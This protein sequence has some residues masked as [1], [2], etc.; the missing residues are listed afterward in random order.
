MKETPVQTIRKFNPGMLQS[1]LE[2]I[3]QFVARG[4]ELR[5]VLDV[6]RSNVD[7][8]S[9]QHV[10]IVAPRGRGKTMLLARVAAELRTETA[11]SEHLL[12]VRVIEESHEILDL[13][14]LWLETLFQLAREVATDNP[15]LARDLRATHASLSSRWQEQALDEH[16][17]AAVLDAADLLDKQLVLMVENLQALCESNADD[18]GWKLR[19]TLQSEPK[20]ILLASAT[21]RFEGLDDAEQAF[22]ELFRT[23]ELHALSTDECRRLWQAAS[24]DEATGRQIR[25]LEILTGGSPRLIM[26]VAEFARHRS[27][28]LLMEELAALIDEHS[29]YF[30]SHI[31]I[32]PKTERRVYL[33]VIDLWKPSKPSEIA[34]RARRDIRLVSATLGRLVDRGAVIV[35][36]S[37]RKRLYSAT[38]RLYCLYYKLRRERDEAVVVRHLIQ[39]MSVFYSEAELT[40]LSGTL[41]AEGWRSETTREGI[42]RALVDTREFAPVFTKEVLR[43]TKEMG[44]LHQSLETCMHEFKAASEGDD[45]GRYL[46]AVHTL[47]ELIKQSPQLAGRSDIVNKLLSVVAAATA[48]QMESGNYELAIETIGELVERFGD[49]EAPEIQVQ[50]ARALVDKGAALARLGD[51]PGAISAM[52]EVRRRFGTGGVT[53]VWKR[54]ARPLSEKADLMRDSGDPVAEQMACYEVGR[55]L[56]SG[57]RPEIQTEVARALVG[58]GSILAELREPEAAISVSSEVV[59]RFGDSAAPKTQ[60]QVARALILKGHQ[61][62]G[63]GDRDGARETFD[64]L[65][66]RFGNSDEP[67]L[68]VE[69]AQVLANEHVSEGILRSAQASLTKFDQVVERRYGNVSTAGQAELR[70]L[71]CYKAAMRAALGDNEGELALLDELIQRVGATHLPQVQTLVAEAF[72][73]KSELLVRLGRTEA[74]LRSC[75][76][77]DRSLGALTAK[78]RIQLGWRVAR[79]RIK[80]LLAH[81]RHPGALDAFQANYSLFNPRNEMMIKGITECV[82]ELIQ[83]GIAEDAIVGILSSDREESGVLVPLVTALRE[84]IGQ[85]VRV[86]TEVREVAADIQEYLEGKESGP[87]Q[88]YA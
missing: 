47:L 10:L 24:G 80:A 64:E 12:P 81:G 53:E 2:V 63:L 36:G 18:F 37:G 21:S 69:V 19:H 60:T 67:D 31:E 16:A 77:A 62:A 9:C 30:R 70:L 52:D 26:M 17:R 87:A 32:L 51:R 59:E 40:D 23:V 85:D 4:H 55:A 48:V 57:E 73:K 15:V 25:P 42:Q 29:E 56:A 39:F 79:A 75:R 86:P 34:A 58:K 28:S 76:E 66:R 3:D 45:P 27:L 22:F 49:S 1:D 74:A 71:L 46:G 5:I 88:I 82:R 54:S 8:P 6:L 83:A 7:S 13:A 44:R 50:V 43:Q 20:I 41:I 61:L 65:V 38:E 72:V 11:L 14:D 68:L 35:D 33:A 78:Y 84:R